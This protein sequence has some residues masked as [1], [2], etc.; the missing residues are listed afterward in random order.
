MRLVVL[1]ALALLAWPSP[2]DEERLASPED[3]EVLA[4]EEQ[5]AELLLRL[6]DSPPAGRGPR[7]SALVERAAAGHLAS[8]AADGVSGLEL[9]AADL[10]KDFPLLATSRPF[11]AQRN[12]LALAAVEDCY[13]REKDESPCNEHLF[14]LVRG[15]KSNLDLLLASARLARDKGYPGSA[16]AILELGL[17]TSL[18]GPL[19]RHVETR[20]AVMGSL[21]Y[22]KGEV[23]GLALRVARQDC[24]TSLRTEL[25]GAWDRKPAGNLSDSLCEILRRKGA[26]GKKSAARCLKK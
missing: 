6:N 12:R 26:L 3:L 13:G 25:S 17:A 9:V 5:W 23:R 1:L 21:D 16:L 20:A 24:W 18:K 14:E 4:A 15:D 2:A 22:P 10:V 8:L 19:C 7:W 11:M